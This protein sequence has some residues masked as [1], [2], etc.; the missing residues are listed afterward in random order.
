[1]ESFV[2]ELKGTP[3]DKRYHGELMKT[4][5][6]RGDKL[7]R[8]PNDVDAPSEM[9][10]ELESEDEGGREGGNAEEEEWFSEE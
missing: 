3:D 8:D 9:V 1:M 2:A 7:V 10:D 5:T 4:H 6:M